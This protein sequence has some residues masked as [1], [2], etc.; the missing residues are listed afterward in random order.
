MT[1]VSVSQ[2]REIKKTSFTAVLE[3][4]SF[5]QFL[6]KTS[7]DGFKNKNGNELSL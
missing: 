4:V 1:P 5:I 6:D 3:N 7:A 2:R